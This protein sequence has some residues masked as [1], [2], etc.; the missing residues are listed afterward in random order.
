MET[1]EAD[2]ED[3]M[4]TVLEKVPKRTYR[5]VKDKGG[6]FGTNVMVST[7]VLPAAQTMIDTSIK[8][9]EENPDMKKNFKVMYT[10]AGDP[11]GWGD[12]IK[13]AGFTWNTYCPFRQGSSALQESWRRRNS[14]LRPRRWFPH[15]VGAGPFNG[16]ASG[17]GGGGI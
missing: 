12:K 9:R 6:V 17:C 7:E 2:P 14:S 13:G 15:L 10:S 11:L 5:M 1:G 8:V 4:A 3:D 16:F